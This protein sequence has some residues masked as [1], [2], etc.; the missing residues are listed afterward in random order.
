V[1]ARPDLKWD[2]QAALG[3]LDARLQVSATLEA[4]I[5]Q[6]VQEARPGDRVLIMSNGD[7]GGVHQ[8]LLDRLGA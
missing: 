7:F 8:K 2:A 1:Y 6:V 4:L 5:E 3:S